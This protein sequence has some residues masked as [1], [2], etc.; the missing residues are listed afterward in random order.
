MDGR[1]QLSIF[2]EAKDHPKSIFT[3]AVFPSDVLRVCLLCFHI[4][5]KINFSY[6]RK[7]FFC[8]MILSKPETDIMRKKSNK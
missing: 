4:F 1:K 8:N 5:C 7:C 3:T 6:F 2:R